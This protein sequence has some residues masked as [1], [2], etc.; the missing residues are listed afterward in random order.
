MLLSCSSMIVPPCRKLWCPKCWNQLW[1][2]SGCKKSTSFLT[3]CLRYCQEI[4]NFL[5]CEVW[6]CLTISIKTIVLICRKPS[7]SSACK[8]ISFIIPVFCKILQRNSKLVI[9]GNLSMHGHTHLKW[10]FQFEGN[11][12]VYLKAKKS[13]SSIHFLWDIGNILQ[14]CY[15]RYFGN[16][17]LCTPKLIISTRRKLLFICRQKTTSSPMFFWRYC[18]DVETSYFGYFGQAWLCTPKMKKWKF[19]CLSPC[20]K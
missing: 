11:F 16:V 19:R 1:Y 13:T 15:L 4:A 12:N 5:F 7:C 14:T 8:K 17:W 9:S 18:K 6:K 2:F 20:Q 10:S 3:S